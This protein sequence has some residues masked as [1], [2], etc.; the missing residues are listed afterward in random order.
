MSLAKLHAAWETE[1]DSIEMNILAAIG[2]LI[3]DVETENR[4]IYMR[5]IANLTGYNELFI[6]QTLSKL[7]IDRQDIVKSVVGNYVVA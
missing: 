5:D 7:A 6:Y 2:N 3:P 1:V 4:I